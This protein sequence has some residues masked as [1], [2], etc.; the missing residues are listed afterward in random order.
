MNEFVAGSLRQNDE[1]PR[2]AKMWIQQGIEIAFRSPLAPADVEK[3]VMTRCQGLG[4]KMGV[5]L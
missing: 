2:L 5:L 4:G 3:E 1:L